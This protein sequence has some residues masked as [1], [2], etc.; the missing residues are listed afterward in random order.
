MGVSHPLRLPLPVTVAQG[1]K[2]TLRKT[3]HAARIGGDE[4]A[5]L[6]PHTDL[7][8]AKQILRRVTRNL[9]T[10]MEKHQWPVTF[11]IGLGSFNKPELGPNAVLDY[12]DGLMYSAK[13]GGK[14]ALIC[15]RYPEQKAVNSGD[16]HRGIGSSGN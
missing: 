5:I 2:S 7:D 10:G 15:A 1:I 12:C 14:N 9:A 3:D 6:L 8:V 4:F 16:G 13:R 11:S